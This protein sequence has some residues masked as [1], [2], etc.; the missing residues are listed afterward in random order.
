MMWTTINEFMPI[1]LLGVFGVWLVI[2]MIKEEI[3]I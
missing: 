1:V 3:T 2:I